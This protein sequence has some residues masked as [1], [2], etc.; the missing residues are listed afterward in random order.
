MFVKFIYNTYI[1]DGS[2]S[3]VKVKSNHFYATK[4]KAS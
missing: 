4:I 3:F 1:L 2:H